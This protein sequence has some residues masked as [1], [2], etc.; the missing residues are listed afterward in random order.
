MHQTTKHM[1]PAAD[2]AVH[3]PAAEAE[4]VAFLGGRVDVRLTGEHTRGW[5]CIHDSRLPAGTATP[6]HVHPH[7]DESFVVLEGSVEY[8][9]DG[10]RVVAQ[11]GDALH[12][13][14]GISH[15]FRVVSP[16]G[17][18]MLGIGAPAGHERFF[19][20]AGDPLDAPLPPDMGRMQ[21][22]ADAVWFELLGPP[23]FGD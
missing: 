6:L 5:L 14:R 21:A 4:S 7:D 16:E 9:L 19:A 15:A 22:A 17:A 2:R 1:S 8:V 13:P 10:T 11:A 23:P 20:L 18:R 12:V 3:V